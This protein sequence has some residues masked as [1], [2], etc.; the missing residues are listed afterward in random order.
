MAIKL[1]ALDLDGTLLTSDKKITT[2]TK[3]IIARAMSR[4]VTVTIA[5]G[6]MLRSALY[7]ARLLASDAPVVC[8]NGGYV[9][10]AEGEPV[11][12]RYFDPALTAA[13]L[14]FAYERGWYVNWYRGM[15]IYASEYRP[16][17][18]TAYVTT[19]GFVVREVGDDYL[20]YTEK[21][22]QFVDAS[23]IQ[24]LAQG[25]IS[26]LE[27][28]SEV[29]TREALFERFLAEKLRG[30]VL[31]DAS[32]A[33]EGAKAPEFGKELSAAQLKEFAAAS[34]TDIYVRSAAGK[35]D[36][37]PLIR[38][39]TFV[40]KLRE[41][42]ECKPFI[43]GIT[44]AA[45]ATDS[46]LSAASFQQTAQILAGAAVRGQIDPLHGL[47]ENVIIGHLIPAGT[48]AEPF[49][50]IAS[51]A[52]VEEESTPAPIEAVTEEEAREAIPQEEGVSTA[53]FDE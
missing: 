21:V 48:G 43:H 34:P 52:D 47:K 38:E 22:P 17:Y 27:T 24:G 3:D 11:F 26:A 10:T 46:F 50:G 14:T 44:K 12:A 23:V 7:F 40:R 31:L 2:R 9:G 28:D 16:E 51:A 41:S 18:F 35:A 25:E 1:I 32:F 53:L 45:L 13:F 29:Q 49:R 19:R 42:P 33:K 37:Y 8:C 39:V 20:R 6:R 5:T 36:E 15:D 30:K 4:G